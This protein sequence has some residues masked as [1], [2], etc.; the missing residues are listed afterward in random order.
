MV[1]TLEVPIVGSS[2]LLAMHL[3]FR[4]IHI[5]DHSL[6]WRKRV[7][8]FRPLG[9][10]SCQPLEVVLLGQSFCLWG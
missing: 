3:I 2:F 8:I 5:Q 10:H 1:N 7:S 6:A 9:I 4:S